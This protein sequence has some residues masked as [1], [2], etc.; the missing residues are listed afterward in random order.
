MAETMHADRCRS[1]D[2]TKSIEVGRL[3]Y[4]ESPKSIE[5]GRS[6]PVEAPKSIEVGRS[7]CSSSETLTSIVG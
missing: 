3:G 6:G 4:V 5:V 1:C 2:A 7:S